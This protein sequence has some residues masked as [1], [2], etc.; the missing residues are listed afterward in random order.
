MGLSRSKLATAVALAAACGAVAPAATAQRE[1]PVPHSPGV[2]E[3]TAGAVAARS[4]QPAPPRPGHSVRLSNERTLSRWAF[5]LRRAV[6]RRAPSAGARVVKVLRTSVPGTG[7]PEL[8]LVLRA[9]TTVRGQVWVQVRLPMRPNNRTGWIL[10]RRLGAYQVVRKQL[11][12]DRRRFR[13]SLYAVVRGRWR[14]VWTSRI[15]VGQPQWPTP[16]GRFY[17]RER[18]I[19]PPV[20]S[21]R[22]WY[23]PFAFGTSAHSPSLSGGNWGDGIVGI[24]GTGWPWLIP[25]RISHGC[26]RVYNAKIQR[27]RRLMPL[28]TPIR[29]R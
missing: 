21:A 29:I 10:R 1:I 5:L 19:V 22:A 16:A 15:G 27:L 20:R 6:A 13:A 8:L 11:I 14:R 18:L 23:G 25:G 24:H 26:V 12:I 4:S 2:P 28:G 7:S 9:H 3:R 17:V